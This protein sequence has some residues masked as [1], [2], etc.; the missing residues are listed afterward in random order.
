MKKTI[1]IT[2]AGGFIGSHLLNLLKENYE[3]FALSHKAPIKS[4][5]VN[6]LVGNLAK[7][8]SHI[9]PKKIDLVLHLAQSNFYRDPVNNGQDIFDV[10]TLSTFNLLNWA[11]K[12][13]AQKFIYS[14]TANV[15][16]S[17]S[18]ILTES[19]MV[20]PMS[21]YAASKAS[22]EMLVNQ[23]SSCFHTTILRVFT[24]YGPMQKNMLIAQMIE[25]LKNNNEISLAGGKGIFLTPLYIADAVQIIVQMLDSFEYDSGDVFN[26]SGLEQT[27]L[28][29]I[30]STLA[31][32]LEVKPNLLITDGTPVSLMGCSRKI[33]KLLNYSNLT[34]LQAGLEFSVHG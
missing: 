26:L 22:A 12:A 32:I 2:G 29:E 34:S 18:G 10:N 17:N 3:I 1:L 13:G 4:S 9:L 16:E 27:N 31:Q 20:K 15:Y 5:G 21:L 28:A 14:S 8:I 25:R 6:V 30:V 7:N 19:S 33:L 23:F 24:V 11:Q